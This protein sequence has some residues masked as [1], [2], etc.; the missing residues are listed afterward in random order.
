[1]LIAEIGLKKLTTEQKDLI[2]LLTNRIKILEELMNSIQVDV[3]MLKSTDNKEQ[4]GDSANYND[5]SFVFEPE[6]DSESDQVATGSS[7]KHSSLT[8][9]IAKAMAN[10]AVIDKDKE[11]TVEPE[12]GRNDME[13]DKRDDAAES[14]VDPDDVHDEDIKGP[15]R[16]LFSHIVEKQGPWIEVKN[17]I[18]G[19]KMNSDNNLKVAVNN[20]NKQGSSVQRT[21]QSSRGE[22]NTLIIGAK[23]ESSTLLY[24]RNVCTED[25][26]NEELCRDVKKYG[27]Q[28]GLRI[29]HAEV[30]HNNY[31]QD[32]VGCRLRVPCSQVEEAISKQTWPEGL[33]CRKWEPRNNRGPSNSGRYGRKDHNG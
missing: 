23:R 22:S 28:V 30:V 1:M 6:R 33:V 21:V 19:K 2:N 18:E 16:E 4:R 7:S 26:T 12:M 11:A 14:Q 3:T 9:A 32:V 24:L 29:M 17:K 13:V 25:R 5:V 20:N 8:S 27:R 31:C 10:A 15:E